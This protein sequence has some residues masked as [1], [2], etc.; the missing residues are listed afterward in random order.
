MKNSHDEIKKLL[1][2][3]KSMLSTKLI[4]ED[5]NRIKKIHNLIT[6]DEQEDEELLVGDVTKKTNVGNSIEK[7]IEDDSEKY[8]ETSKKDKKQAYRISGGIIV[9]HGKESTDLQI[10]VDEKIAFQETMEEFVNEVA[11]LVD[12]NKLNVY[13]Q[14]V[15][16]SGKIIDFDL[17]FFFT[18]GEDNGIY[19]QG[20]MMKT[21]DNFLDVINKLKKYYDKFK[22]K[23]SK[24]L[25]QRKKTN[26]DENK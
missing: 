2:A 23:W 13:P 17:Q 3:S 12:F 1:K 7:N 4:K 10:T 14:N 16:W 21:D 26:S 18:I 5:E 19:I 9:L 15:E 25:A 20:D 8:N 24:I 22:S 6:E 11:E